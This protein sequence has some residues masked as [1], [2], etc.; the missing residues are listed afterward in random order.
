M[1]WLAIACLDPIA[2]GII[3]AVTNVT[4]TWHAMSCHDMTLTTPTAFLHT[5]YRI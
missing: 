2:A 3:V 1:S 4:S 5:L